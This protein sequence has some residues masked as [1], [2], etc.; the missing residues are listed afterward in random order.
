MCRRLQT[1]NTGLHS[2]SSLRNTSRSCVDPHVFVVSTVR[3]T[4]LFGRVEFLQVG[5]RFC[6][7]Q[8]S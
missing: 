6:R 2:S 1:D 4:V 5:G 7:R 3:D 8:D